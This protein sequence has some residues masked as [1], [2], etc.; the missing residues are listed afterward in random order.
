MTYNP[1]DKDGYLTAEEKR[2]DHTFSKNT[3]DP[4]INTIKVKDSGDDSSLFDN[5]K[6]LSEDENK[7]V[8]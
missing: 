1:N 5:Q 7:L 6:T 3:V 8:R 4:A 2:A